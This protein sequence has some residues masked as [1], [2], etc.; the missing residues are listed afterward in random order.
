MADQN[1]EQENIVE[2]IDEEGNALRFEHMMTLEHKGNAYI[3]LAP[4]E[5]MEDIGE[6][7]LVIMRV[8]KDADSDEDVYAT[9]EDEAE[10]DEVFE[11]Y[12]KIAEADD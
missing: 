12:L 2:L 8:E 9:I 11:E 5:P 10:L 4:A 3:C 7:E 6:D 1:M